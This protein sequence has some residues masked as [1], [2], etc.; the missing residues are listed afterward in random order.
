MRTIP[1]SV[2]RG[3]VGLVPQETFL[4]S[5]TVRENVDFGLPDADLA[6]ARR[7]T[8]G[9]RAEVAP[10]AKD[11]RDFPLGYETFVGGRGITLS[12][13]QKHRAAAGPGLATDPAHPRVGRRP[14]LRGHLHRGGDPGGLTGVMAE[15]TTFL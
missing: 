12:G 10:L 5:E 6:E 3:A 11:V 15:R 4:F 7:R 2:L 14:G 9:P 8:R 1:L 13:G